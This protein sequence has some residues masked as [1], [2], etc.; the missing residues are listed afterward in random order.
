MGINQ[1]TQVNASV[2]MDRALYDEIK[3]FAKKEKRSVSAQMCV[4]L[5]ERMQ[6]ER[7]RIK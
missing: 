7:E 4:W 1:E 2:V 5:E 3:A 6:H